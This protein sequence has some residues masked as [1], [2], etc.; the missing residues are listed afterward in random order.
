MH[1]C[2]LWKTLLHIL[3]DLVVSGTPAA[4][5]IFH[6]SMWNLRATSVLGDFTGFD[7]AEL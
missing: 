4:R 1:K 6:R 5:H 7:A 2:L 3:R